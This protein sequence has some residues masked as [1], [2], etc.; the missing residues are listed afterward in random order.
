MFG[1]ACNAFLG[2]AAGQRS[3]ANSLK[4]RHQLTDSEIKSKPFRLEVTFGH[5]H[6]IHSGRH[7]FLLK[8][9]TFPQNTFYTIAHDCC[10]DFFGDG[11]T[12]APVIRS[13]VMKIH[14]HGEV[15][16]MKTATR[17]ITA[18]EVGSPKQSVSAG[19]S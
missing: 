4:N 3:S 19:T 10:T 16:G 5:D 2:G 14:K 1:T 6:E 13:I 7:E 8:S 15:F 18:R 9:E 17:I 12:Y 11:H